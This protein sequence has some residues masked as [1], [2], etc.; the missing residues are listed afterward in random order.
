[1][2]NS[3]LLRNVVSFQSEKPLAAWNVSQIVCSQSCSLFF[4]RAQFSCK[5]SPQM[6]KKIIR[7]PV[8]R[9]VE[10]YFDWFDYFY[11]GK[12]NFSVL[13]CFLCLNSMKLGSKLEPKQRFGKSPGRFSE[14]HSCIPHSHWKSLEFERLFKSNS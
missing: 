10:R 9:H 5:D 1:M 4:L 12:R 14:S 7:L 8:T 13:S 3:S 11:S 2:R 6:S